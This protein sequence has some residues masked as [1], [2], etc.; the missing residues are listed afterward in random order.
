MDKTK[1]MQFRRFA[2]QNCKDDKTE[3]FDF[4]G[5][6]FCNSSSK[7]DKYRVHIQTSKKK[8]KVKI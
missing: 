6:T 7:K 8:M 5:L 1:I 2:K 3:A 4:L